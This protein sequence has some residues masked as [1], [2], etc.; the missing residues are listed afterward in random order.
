MFLLISFEL[1]YSFFSFSGDFF[2]KT[3]F[4]LNYHKADEA[5]MEHFIKKYYYNKLITILIALDGM[6]TAIF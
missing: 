4:N 3:E 1:L 2:V 5:Q 6:H